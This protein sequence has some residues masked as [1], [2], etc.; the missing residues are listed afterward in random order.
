MHTL[1]STVEGSRTHAGEWGSP[2]YVEVV[3][4]DWAVHCCRPFGKQFDNIYI[5][6]LK[7]IHTS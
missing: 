6:S 1:L 5:E 4:G 2:T 7:N 3:I